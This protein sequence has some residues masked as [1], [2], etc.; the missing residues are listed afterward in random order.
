M[1][2][3]MNTVSVCTGFRGGSLLIQFSSG[4]VNSFLSR[5]IINLL[6]LTYE[7]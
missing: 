6:K 3:G 2:Q 5:E 7:K 4:G 1:R